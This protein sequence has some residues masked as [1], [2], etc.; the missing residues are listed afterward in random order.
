MPRLVQSIGSG[1]TV[2]NDLNGFPVVKATYNLLNQAEDGARTPAR[3]F[4]ANARGL[5]TEDEQPCITLRDLNEDEIIF[6]SCRGAS[7][8]VLVIHDSSNQPFGSLR[9]RAGRVGSAWEIVT[10]TGSQV[11][12]SMSTGEEL[13]F[14]DCDGREVALTEPRSEEPDQRAVRVGPFA[15]AGLVVLSLLTIDLLTGA[16][17]EAFHSQFWSFGQKLKCCC[18]SDVL[19]LV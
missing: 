17:N 4:P 1:G 7:S 19:L 8:G 9:P 14:S 15:D 10:A 6:G 5:T 18:L 2:I 3:S 12:I 13:S 11:H 16:R